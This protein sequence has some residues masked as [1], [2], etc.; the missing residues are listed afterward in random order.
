MKTLLLAL[1][2]TSF[3]TTA[4]A[5]ANCEKHPKEDW[6]TPYEM[7]K[8][9]VNEYNFAIKKFK[10]SGNCYEIYGWENYE[11]SRDLKIE[12]YFDTK[13]GKVVKKHID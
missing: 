2:A 3:S 13:T 6:L 7:Q 1:L 12:V 4:F 9:I 10:V 8:K 5:R 11:N